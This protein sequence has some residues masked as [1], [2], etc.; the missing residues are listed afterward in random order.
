MLN[1]PAQQC[2]L[3]G[4]NQTDQLNEVENRRFN[5]RDMD[6]GDDMESCNSSFTFNSDASFV[7]AGNAT[8]DNVSE[9]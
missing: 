5:Q 8:V 2:L 9:K 3:F 6:N 1:S 4:K 7:H